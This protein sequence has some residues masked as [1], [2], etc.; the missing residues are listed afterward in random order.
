[1]CRILAV[2]GR[3]Q[4]G[5]WRHHREGQRAQTVSRLH[6]PEVH[7]HARE[8]ASLHDVWFPLTCLKRQPRDGKCEKLKYSPG[9]NYYCHYFPDYGQRTH[10]GI[11]VNGLQEEELG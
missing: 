5:V 7:G 9:R 4:P 1:M 3:D 2:D 10:R 8:F 6:R 11:I